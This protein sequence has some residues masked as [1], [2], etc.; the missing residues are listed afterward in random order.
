MKKYL[1][2]SRFPLTPKMIA[3]GVYNHEEHELI[4]TMLQEL[5]DGLSGTEAIDNLESL[6]GFVLDEPCETVLVDAG[7][8][9]TQELIQHIHDMEY[10][11]ALRFEY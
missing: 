7:Q 3:A 4:L 8:S 9:Y 2:Y 5:A 10:Q 1:N 11:T 6:G